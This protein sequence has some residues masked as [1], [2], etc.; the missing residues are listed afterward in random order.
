ML[1]TTEEVYTHTPD[2]T[3]FLKNETKSNSFLR[4]LMKSD[5][6]DVRF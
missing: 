6:L 1:D 4:D 5:G 2:K 3:E